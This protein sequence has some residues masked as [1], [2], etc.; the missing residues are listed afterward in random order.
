MKHYQYIGTSLRLTGH[1]ALGRFVDG[2]FLVQ[3]DNIN[4]PW[5]HGWHETN[6]ND[7]K[8]ETEYEH[9]PDGTPSATPIIPHSVQPS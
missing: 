7:W 4:H 9:I 2:K 8:E 6:P 1:W 3:V 5:A